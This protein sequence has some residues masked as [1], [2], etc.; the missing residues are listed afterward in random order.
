MTGQTAWHRVNQRFFMAVSFWESGAILCPAKINLILRIG[1][2]RRDSYHDIASLMVKLGWGDL[3]RLNVRPSMEV[4]LNLDCPGLS[5]LEPSRNLAYQ[6]AELFLRNFKLQCRV[7]L[8][9]EKRIPTDAGLGGGSS[10]AAMV[11]KALGD[12]LVQTNPRK[13]SKSA[14]QKK[15][16]TM[17]SRLGS[18]VAFLVQDEAAA[19]CRGRGEKMSPVKTLPS[20]PMVLIFPKSKISTAWAYRELDRLRGPKFRQD[21]QWET[22]PEWLKQGEAGRSIPS[23]DNDFLSLALTAHEE[24]QLSLEAL[25]GSGALAGGMTGSGS[26]F[27]GIYRDRAE[28]EKSATRLRASGWEALATRTEARAKK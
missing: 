14:I 13:Y 18:D 17:A 1:P 23:I 7:D 24:L 2:K 25:T 4:E 26:C 9:I 28:A 19:W 6:A 8:T 3:L 12:F 27:F 11:L 20:W 21:S 15:L 22:M 5:D 10:D 16:L